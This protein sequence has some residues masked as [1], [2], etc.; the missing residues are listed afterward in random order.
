MIHLI[1]GMTIPFILFELIK[2]YYKKEM[3]K[4][5]DEYDRKCAS[6]LGEGIKEDDEPP[7]G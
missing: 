3:K 2:W 4:I 1:I 5:D 7:A 6:F